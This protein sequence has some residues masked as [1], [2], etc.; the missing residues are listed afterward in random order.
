MNTEERLAAI[1]V[2]LKYQSNQIDEIKQMLSDIQSSLKERQNLNGHQDVS[3]ARLQTQF[4]Q[5]E[6][7]LKQLNKD[8]DFVVRKIY[9]IVGVLTALQLVAQ[10]VWR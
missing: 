5:H 6:E 2:A 4:A 9:W 10:I 1:E 8:V 7:D 3:I